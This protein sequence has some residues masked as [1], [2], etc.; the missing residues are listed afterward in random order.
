M[1]RYIKSGTVNTVQEINSELEKIATAQV[2][3]LSRQG[4]APNAMSSPLDMD[5]NRIFNLPAPLSNG[6]PLRFEDLK[7]IIPPVTFSTTTS[8]IN[9]L[10]GGFTVGD[11]VE[12]LGYSV[13]GD[14]GAGTW[15]KTAITGQTVSRN[16]QQIGD[17]LLNDASGNQWNLDCTENIN[18]LAL[19]AVRD[20][21]TNTHTAITAAIFRASTGTASTKV[22]CPAG[23]YA[24]TSSLEVQQH[25]VEIIGVGQGGFQSGIAGIRNSAFTRFV[26][27]GVSSATASMIE[28]RTPQGTNQKNAGGISKIML[29]CQNLAGQGLKLVSWRGGSFNDFVV[30]GPTANGILLTTSELNLSAQP[31]DTIKNSFSNVYVTSKN[32]SNN[33]STGLKL[34]REITSPGSGNSCYNTF[35]N[36]NFERG[37]LE[38]G[39]GVVL[40]NTDNNTFYNL[41]C[42]TVIFSSFDNEGT[43]RYNN[44]F[45]CEANIIARAGSVGGESS[46]SNKVCGLNKSNGF[47][48]V[49]IEA[50]AGGSSRAEIF[51][52]WSDGTALLPRGEPLNGASISSTIINYYEEGNWAI[53]VKGTSSNGSKVVTNSE[54]KYVRVGNLVTVSGF[55]NYNTFT[56]TGSQLIS[57]LPYAVA[58]QS[59]FLISAQNLNFTGQLFGLVETGESDVRLRTTTSGSAVSDV[60]ADQAAI[61]WV[62]GSYITS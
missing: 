19:G 41:S 39:A 2:D 51:I 60:P 6:E 17:A 20:G 27:K 30:Y 14:G 18:V 35:I 50:G 12:T 55:I 9:S 53:N 21:V 34:G 13:A 43:A 36:C 5:S 56:G 33:G 31:Y 47:G 10:A 48:A 38:T 4:V 28:F 46:F 8:L 58:N 25:N 61:L 1:T 62:S 26:W 37:E 45:G 29:D 22:Y 57:G 44:I 52:E 54:G 15:Q 3:L 23:V 49:T 40:G 32:L 7:N 16:P 42:A 59:M 24:L 11:I